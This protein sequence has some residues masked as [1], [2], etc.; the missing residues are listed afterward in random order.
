MTRLDRDLAGGC[1]AAFAGGQ[2]VP[3]RFLH[4]THSTADGPLMHGQQSFAAV[5]RSGGVQRDLG[6]R[7][8]D[9]D[10]LAGADLAGGHRV[11]V[12]REGDQTVLADRPQV[13]FGDQIRGR[14]QR[15][16]S[17]VIPGGAMSDHFGVG[18][19]DL[20]PALGHPGR[21]RGVHLLDAGEGPPGQDVVADDQDLA[22]DQAEC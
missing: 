21:E 11:E 3:V 17:R 12:A 10:E 13:P 14:R 18:C 5:V 6:L 2:P 7:G 15:F 16:E 4:D 22:L 1:P 9:L 20:S 8:S 19:V